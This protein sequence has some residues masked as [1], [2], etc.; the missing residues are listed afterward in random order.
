LDL[1]PDPNKGSQ[2]NLFQT[3]GRCLDTLVDLE[4]LKAQGSTQVLCV[5]TSAHSPCAHAICGL[6]ICGGGGCSFFPFFLLN[7]KIFFFGMKIGSKKKFALFF[8]KRELNNLL[9]KNS[10]I[11][12]LAGFERPRSKFRPLL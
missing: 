4:G 8:L 6:A 7:W 12:R 5:S 11:N 1:P 2:N 3:V 10:K 9:Q